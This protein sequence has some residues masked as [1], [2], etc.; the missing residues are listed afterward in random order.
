MP[1]RHPDRLYTFGIG[2]NIIA[3]LDELSSANLSFISKHARAH[4]RNQFAAPTGDD[5]AHPFITLSVS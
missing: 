4:D 1:L 3:T 2:G 5:Q